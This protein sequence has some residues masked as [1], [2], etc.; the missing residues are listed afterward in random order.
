MTYNF[1][2]DTWYD[3]EIGHLE[4]LRQSGKITESEFRRLLEA[5]DRRHGDMWH[6]LDGTYQIA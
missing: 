2:P 6:R 4:R 1:D 5:L 3:M